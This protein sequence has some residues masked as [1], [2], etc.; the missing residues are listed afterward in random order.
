MGAEYLYC[1]VIDIPSWI[2]AIAAVCIVGL[3][4]RTLL[5][6]KDYASDTKKIA[7]AGLLQLENSQMPF[8]AVIMRPAVSPNDVGGWGIE[9]QGF[10]PAINV[11]YS[12]HVSGDS[13]EEYTESIPKGGT[14]AMHGDISA[15][16][17]FNQALVIQYES[18]SGS[19][20]RSTIAMVDNNIRT[21]FQKS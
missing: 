20:Y 8:L 12:G 21:Q 13:R 3:T 1:A 16:F 6:L 2:Q 4:L 18:V 19:T 11:R 14:L 7:N 15:A 9:N 5:V 10:G 17:R